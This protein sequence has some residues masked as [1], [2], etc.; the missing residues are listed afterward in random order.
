MDVDESHKSARLIE[1]GHRIP[2]CEGGLCEARVSMEKHLGDIWRRYP[3][4]AREPTLLH[5]ILGMRCKLLCVS[6]SL[7]QQRI[8]GSTV[9]E[10][11][12]AYCSNEDQSTAEQLKT[13]TNTHHLE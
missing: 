11:Q 9:H 10:I 8:V 2:K 4:T 6:A 7:S 1:C 3:H 13:E 12:A 5:S